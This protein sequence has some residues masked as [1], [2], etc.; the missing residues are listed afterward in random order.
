MVISYMVKEY[1]VIKEYRFLDGKP[2]G[3]SLLVYEGGE[4]KHH[5]RSSSNDINDLARLARSK[6]LVFSNQDKFTTIPAPIILGP[7]NREPVSLDVLADF[8]QDFV[9]YTQLDRAEAC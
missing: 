9:S 1:V 3:F 7:V 8:H 2:A 5:I 6:G 4:E